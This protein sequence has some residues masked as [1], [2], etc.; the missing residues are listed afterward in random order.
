MP[1][2]VL[3][4]TVP[5]G[6][7]DAFA[8]FLREHQPA[9]L[10]MELGQPQDDQLDTVLELVADADVLVVGLAAQQRAVCRRVYEVARHLKLVQK[11]GSRAFGLDLHAAAELRVPVSLVSAPT[12]V[13]CAEH[14]FLLILAVVKKLLVANRAIV[15][16]DGEPASQASTAT[17][18]AAN[19]AN[20]DGI[21]LMAGKTLGLVGMGDIAIEVARRA[22]AFGLTVLYTDP[23]Q[24]PADEA[25]ELGLAYRELDDLLAQSDIVS[26][27]AAH[28]AKT[29]K[30][31]N[32][33]RLARMKHSAILVNTARGGLVDE[34]A[35]IAA[36]CK[37]HL[38]GAALDAWA[39]E[40]TPRDNP[41]LALDNVVATPHVAAGTLPPD[42]LFAAILPNLLSAMQGGPIQGLVGKDPRPVASLDAPPASELETH[43]AHNLLHDVDLPE[44]PLGPSEDPES[45]NL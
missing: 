30:L 25:D 29:E 20:L 35:L 44:I 41:L 27:H 10:A 11:V 6:W 26:L 45:M 15:N 14:T 16:S 1:K 18:Y 28:T 34:D 4:E 12:H 37:E 7:F 40:P 3:Y 24:L 43:H 42:A 13:A 39:Q 22:S 33:D 21:G 2:I 31:I 8:A 5:Q 23:D 9:D 19:W 32:A 38:G 17:E 36:L